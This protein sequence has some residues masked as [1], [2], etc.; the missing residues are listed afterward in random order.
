[1]R[2]W[3]QIYLPRSPGTHRQTHTHTHTHTHRSAHASGRGEPSRDD[4]EGG[5][6][7]RP[8]RDRRP[9][10]GKG[11]GG[12]AGK[13]S[14]AA[15]KDAEDSEFGDDDMPFPLDAAT[16]DQLM[17]KRGRPVGAKDTKQRK[18]RM[19]MSVIS[20]AR[21][22]A[23]KPHTHTYTHTLGPRVNDYLLAPCMH[24]T[25][26]TYV[27]DR[28]NDFINALIAHLHVCLGMCIALGH[29]GTREG[30]SALGERVNAP[31]LTILSLGP[32]VSG[33][34]GT[35]HPPGGEGGHNCGSGRTS[36]DAG[37]ASSV[38]VSGSGGDTA[39]GATASH[40]QGPHHLHPK[41]R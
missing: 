26:D 8:D 37:G 32:N 25:A 17:P 3:M 11:V 30:G 22:Y 16:L 41:L 19:G 24:L 14:G 13:D 7:S 21:T 15:G 34:P 27:H 20:L 31:T 2:A 5:S 38:G 9:R 12:R 23:H 36:A 18:K 33:A 6:S 4:Q 39:G 40:P 35:S 28:G 10:G 29:V 1:V